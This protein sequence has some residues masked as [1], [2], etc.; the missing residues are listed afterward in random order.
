MDLGDFFPKLMLKQNKMPRFKCPAST[1][2]S[3]KPAKQT[4]QI[5]G[6]MC[7]P[8][9]FLTWSASCLVK[10]P[11]ITELLLHL[12]LEVCSMN[13]SPF[14]LLFSSLFSFT[15]HLLLAFHFFFSSFK[16][17][18][19]T[20]NKEE[21]HFSCDYDHCIIFQLKKEQQPS[22]L[23]WAFQR[24]FGRGLWVHTFQVPL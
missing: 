5:I 8:P 4:W 17:I 19:R 12:T 15:T 18:S 11:H 23:R 22:Y 20:V 14:S 1:L 10:K 21:R 9:N 16:Y 2:T 13:C 3:S 7:A 6:N 24:R